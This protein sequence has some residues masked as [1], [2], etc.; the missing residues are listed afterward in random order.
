MNDIR[1]FE[2][3]SV[4]GNGAA[5]VPLPISARGADESAE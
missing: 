4:E 1:E 5:T 3:E 2:P